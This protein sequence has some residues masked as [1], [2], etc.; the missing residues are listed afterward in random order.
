MDYD[1]IVNLLASA[2]T[3]KSLEEIAAEVW[4]GKWGTKDT[5]PTRNELLKRA[6]YDPK[7]VQKIVNGMKK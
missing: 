7:A 4:D 3:R 1:G 5:T 6:G 2:P